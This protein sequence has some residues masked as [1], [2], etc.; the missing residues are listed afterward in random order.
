MLGSCA[1]WFCPGFWPHHR[2]AGD[3]LD[4]DAL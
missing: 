4:L 1:L 3:F 2:Y